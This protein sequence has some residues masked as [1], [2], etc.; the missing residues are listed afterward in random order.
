MFQAP[1]HR[2]KTRRFFAM[3]GVTYYTI[4]HTMRGGHRNAVVGIL[5]DMVRGLTLVI[6]FYV[7]FQLIGVR[8]APLR[9][10]FMLYIMNGVFLFMTVSNIAAAGNPT[11]PMIMHPP[12]NTLVAIIA[13]AI[14]TL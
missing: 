5:L 14:T 9:G 1:I 2:T 11:S 8:S 13:A 7:L 12:M 4:V 3:V 10:D 6:T